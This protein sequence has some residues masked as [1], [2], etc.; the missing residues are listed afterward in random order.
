MDDIIYVQLLEEGTR[1]Y[2]PVNAFKLNNDV[3]KILDKPPDDEVWEFQFNDIVQCSKTK[4]SD[5]F[6]LVAVNKIIT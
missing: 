1:C 2:R 4:L 3:Y 5:G 6:E